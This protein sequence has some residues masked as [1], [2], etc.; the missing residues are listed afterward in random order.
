MA[1]Q[2]CSEPS[3]TEDEVKEEVSLSALLNKLSLGEFVQ[4]FEK[5]QVDMESLVSSFVHAN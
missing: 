3:P 4:A 2:D 1:F 5:E